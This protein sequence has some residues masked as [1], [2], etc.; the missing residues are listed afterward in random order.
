M[1]K[2]FLF[3]IAAILFVATSF[4]QSVGINTD[5]SAP[6]A[7]AMLD[8]KN[9]NKGLL[10]PRV[11]L[12]GTGDVTTIPSAAT[13]LLVYNTTAAGTGGSAVIPGYYYWNGT[14]WLQLA[15]SVRDV[16]DEFSAT[17]AQTGFTLTQTPSTNS[18]V[19][20]YVNGIRIS[21]T[22]YTI[23]VNTLTYIPANNGS[24]SLL[25]NDRIQFDYYY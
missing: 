17:G 12:T 15:T 8:V 11:T 22:A 3:F 2:F 14:A 23:S 25:A 13:S 5:G 9:P 24:Y 21:N 20:M 1:K 10:V 7:S 18:K 16:A 6:N 19:K 4:A